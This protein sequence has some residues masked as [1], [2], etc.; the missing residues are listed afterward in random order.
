MFITQKAAEATKDTAGSVVMDFQGRECYNNALSV[1]E[2]EKFCALVPTSSVC[3]SSDDAD[4]RYERQG[5]YG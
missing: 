1:L 4:A 5:D 3:L 2:N